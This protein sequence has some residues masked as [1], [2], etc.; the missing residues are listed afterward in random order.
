[1]KS[2]IHSKL[3]QPKQ[4]KISTRWELDVLDVE[5]HREAFHILDILRILLIICL[6]P[7]SQFCF[8]VSAILSINLAMQHTV[9]QFVY[10]IWLL[11]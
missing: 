11:Y 6:I 4:G 2:K 9:C 1:M 8:L 5:V 7:F 3:A 10:G